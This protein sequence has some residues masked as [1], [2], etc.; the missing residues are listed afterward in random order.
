M[1]E[2]NFDCIIVMHR[3]RTEY[4]LNSIYGRLNL[5]KKSPNYSISIKNDAVTVIANFL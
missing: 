2:L 3:N 5:P 4:G 1:I